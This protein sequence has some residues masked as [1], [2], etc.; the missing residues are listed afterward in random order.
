MTRTGWTGDAPDAEGPAMPVTNMLL[1]GSRGGR[2]PGAVLAQSLARA[3]ADETREARETSA[4][5]LDPDE[6]CANLVGRGYTPGLVSTLAQQLGDTLAELEGE[7]EKIEKAARRAEIAHREH[8]AGRV[9]VFRM[10]AMMD[11]DDGDEGRVRV[12]ERRAGSLQR[13]IAEAQ[14]A[15]APPSQ[16]DPDPFESAAQR[17]HQAFVEVTRQR[18]ADAQA[19]RPA[20]RPFAS[21]GSAVRAE[22]VTCP[23]CL[24]YGATPDQSYLI[25]ADP[26]APA[27][28][29]QPQVVET[30]AG[31]WSYDRNRGEMNRV[32]YR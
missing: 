8:L 14:E 21:R 1:S 15:I 10:Q 9:D 23:D 31:T 3:A 30:D 24:K 26:D 5:V 19:R 4:S 18:M 17:A 20:P 11:G 27:G 2:Q 25:H 32:A 7:R 22:T 6:Y 28:I 13:Q 29:A 12:L 16:R